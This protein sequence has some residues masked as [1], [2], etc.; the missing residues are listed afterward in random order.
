V[1]GRQRIGKTRLLLKATEG[2][3]T[4]YFF[5]SRRAEPYLCQDFQQEISDKLNIPMLGVITDFGKLFQFLMQLSIER[6]FH[7]IIDEFQEF[8]NV[9]PAVYSDM[10]RS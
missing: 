3:P 6:E 2:L 9:N 4:L 8:F 5:V 10:Q 1:T 7:L